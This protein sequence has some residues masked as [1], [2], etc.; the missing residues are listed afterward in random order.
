MTLHWAH[1][2]AGYV[3]VLGGFAL[4]AVTTALRHAAAKRRLAAL[5][6]RQAR[7]GRKAA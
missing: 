5:D 6:P 2:T 3:L 1:V 4:L 7:Q